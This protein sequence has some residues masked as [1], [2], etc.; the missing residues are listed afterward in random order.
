M[1]NV[2]LNK[3]SINNGLKFPKNVHDADTRDKIHKHL[4]DINDIITDEDI[5]R[6]K[7]DIPATPPVIKHSSK[8]HR[9]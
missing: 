6:I 3:Q 8:K 4:S 1:E 7:I 9:K 2:P 5:R